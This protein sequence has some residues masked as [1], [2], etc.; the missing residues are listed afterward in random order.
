MLVIRKAQMDT[1]DAY[2]RA[3]FRRRVFQHVTADF[4]ERSAELGA[5]GVQRLVEGAIAKGVDYGIS[6]EDDL[7]GFVDLSV[8]LGP[9]F[10]ERADLQWAR[11]ILEKESLSGHGKV[12]LIQ[13]LR[14]GAK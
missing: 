11:E 6:S 14:A 7:Q 1:L 12:E 4:P 10:E 8:E 3:A 5:E 2:S 9:D 13:Q